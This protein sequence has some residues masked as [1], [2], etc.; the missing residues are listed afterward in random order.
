MTSVSEV[1]DLSTGPREPAS[2][3]RPASVPKLDGLGL[4]LGHTS[5]GLGLGLGL[6]GTGLDYNPDVY[7]LC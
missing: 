3:S 5:L 6:G 7:T 2:V 4:G 1:L